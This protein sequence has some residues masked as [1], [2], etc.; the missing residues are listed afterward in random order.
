MGQ[1]HFLTTCV[2]CQ[3]VE[4]LEEM[5]DNAREIS[6][7][8]FIKYVPPQQLA[9]VFPEYNWGR[10]QGQGLTMK[11]D[12][13]VSYYKSKYAGIPAVF[14]VHSAIEHVWVCGPMARQA[15]ESQEIARIKK[16]AGL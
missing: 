15:F 12:Y 8:T 10:S 9:E 2:D 4:A 6:Y 14:V 11:S 5:I 13:H 1:C 7:K 16:L 3:D